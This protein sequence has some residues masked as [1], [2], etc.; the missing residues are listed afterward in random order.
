[1]ATNSNQTASME[2]RAECREYTQHTSGAGKEQK[3][4]GQKRH[5]PDPEAE[6]GDDSATKCARKDPAPS[7]ATAAPSPDAGSNKKNGQPVEIK[8]T[9]NE[10]ADSERARVLLEEVLSK[11]L[12]VA[13]NLKCSVRSIK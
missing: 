1:M 8:F 4:T 3:S 2:Q 5:R 6:A 11:I 7:A 10:G 12:A 9:C 13:P